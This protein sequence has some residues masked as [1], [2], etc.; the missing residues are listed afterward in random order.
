M[1]SMEVV[2]LGIS[3]GQSMDTGLMDLIKVEPQVDPLGIQTNDNTDVEKKAFLS[4]DVNLF[5]LNSTRIKTE[6][7]D[8]SDDLTSNVTFGEIAMPNNFQFVKCEIEEELC[9]LDRV[10]EKLKFEVTAEENEVLTERS[11]HAV[12]L[13]LKRSP[14]DSDALKKAV[15]AVIASPGNKM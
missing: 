6:P 2:Q 5:N 3:V 7:E 14:I 1:T 11:C 9:E 4:E 12:S 8:Y 13:E 10:K 15:E